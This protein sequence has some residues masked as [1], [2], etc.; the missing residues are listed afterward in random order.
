MDEEPDWAIILHEAYQS[1]IGVVQWRG[2]LEDDHKHHDEE[3][4][5]DLT[6]I[7]DL[8]DDRIRN[9]I[10][11][12]DRAHLLSQMG[13]GMNYKLTQEGL[14][15][16][17]ERALRDRQEALMETQNDATSILAAFT[18]VL[19]AAALIQAFAAVLNTRG[20]YNVYLGVVYAILL[21]AIWWT[22][23]DWMPTT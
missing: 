4:E 15:V 18:V 9:A 6:Q 20:P 5:F 17:H 14:D 11:F 13:S 1:K 2:D 19:G 23:D 22:M 7:T 12:L 16:A 8:S 21:I 10:A 3:A